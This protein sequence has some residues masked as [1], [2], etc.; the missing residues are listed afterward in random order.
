VNVPPPPMTRSFTRLPGSWLSRELPLPSA[1]M[2]FRHEYVARVLG[3][4]N[5]KVGPDTPLF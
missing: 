4:Q 5:G 2:V 1:A 3:P